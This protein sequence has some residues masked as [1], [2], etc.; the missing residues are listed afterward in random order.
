[1]DDKIVSIADYRPHQ[2]S[3]CACVACGKDF[4]SAF[5]TGVAVLECPACGLSQA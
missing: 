4:V 1:M 2:S 3:Y 5:P